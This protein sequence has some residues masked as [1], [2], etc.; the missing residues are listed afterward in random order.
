MPEM[1]R[2]LLCLFCAR[3][4]RSGLTIGLNLLRYLSTTRVSLDDRR[5]TGSNPRV[6][7]RGLPREHPCHAACHAENE[8]VRRTVT[9]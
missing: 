2:L 5:M 3:P 4:V 8:G 1:R 9:G 7:P 6:V